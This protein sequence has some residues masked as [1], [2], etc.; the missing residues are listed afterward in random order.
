MRT[1]R[2]D[3]L[4]GHG[5]NNQAQQRGLPLLEW[6]SK[7]NRLGS[8]EVF[9]PDRTAL[10]LATEYTEITEK[11]IK[12]FRAFRVFRGYLDDI[13]LSKCHAGKTL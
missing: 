6:V 5:W 1:R 13:S 9:T 12:I 2:S 8:G 7:K 11:T 4:C 3:Q 10:D